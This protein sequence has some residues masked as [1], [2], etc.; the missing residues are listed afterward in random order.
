MNDGKIITILGKRGKGKTLLGFSL[1][2]YA[3]KI[4]FFISIKKPNFISD[5]FSLY[6][7][8]KEFYKDENLKSKIYF[9]FYNDNEY[10]RLFKILTLIRNV[11]IF[12][13]EIDIWYNQYKQNDYIKWLI[14]YSRD[15]GINLIFITRRPVETSTLLIGLTDLLFVFNITHYRDLEY[16]KKSFEFDNIKKI[17]F[18]E[19]FEFYASGNLDIIEQL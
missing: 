7:S 4:S 8:L 19:T 12:I 1:F 18:L 10:N 16:L 11:N 14:K 5:K 9:Q 17:T 15:K 6:H 2:L 3:K 13:D